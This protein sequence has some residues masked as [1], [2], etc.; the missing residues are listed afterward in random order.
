M[1]AALV[2]GAL[3][4]G[5]L[6]VLFDRLA[7]REVRDF[8][9]AKKVNRKLLKKLETKLLSA[10]VLLNDAEEKQLTEPNVKKWLDELKQVLYDADHVMDKINSEALRLKLEKGQ[11]GSGKAS[12]LL[13]FVPTV[14]I[15]FENNVKR[16]LEGILGALNFLLD[17]T[18]LLGLKEVDQKRPPHRLYS[19]LVEEYGVFGRKE[20]KEAIVELLLSDDVGGNGYRISIIPIV[21][22]GGVGK[23]T[24][25]QLV[26][27]ESSVQRHFDLKAWVTVS[28]EFDIFRI[29][30]TILESVTLKKCEIEDIHQLQIELS[31]ALTG[32][33]FLFVHDDVWNENYQLWDLLKSS[34]ESGAHGS[35]IIVTTRSKVVALKMGNIPM[36]DLQTMSDDDCWQLFSKHVFNNTGSD[37]QMELLDIGKQIVRKCKGLPLAV[38][39]VSGLLRSVSNLEEWRTILQSDVWELQFQENQNNNILPALWLSYH[40]LPRHLKQCFAYFSIFPKDY[41][42]YKSE[43]EKIFL[44]WMAEGILQPQE[45]KRMEDV[46][47]EYLNALISRSFFQRSTR[48][49]STLFMHDLTHDL[50]IRVSGEF[51][52]IDH[53]FEDLHSLTSKT[54]HLSY[55]KG[56]D[57][58]KKLE[59][60]FEAKRLRTLLSLPLSHKNLYSK[61]MLTQQGVHELLLTTRGCLRVLS[62]SQSS[63]V[64]LP[65]S[66]GNL[67]HLRYLDV[68]ET[69]VAELPC[70]VCSLYNLQTLLLSS[71]K[72]LTHL[73]T[74]ISKLIN[75]RH[76]MIRDT[77]LKEM[78]PQMCN[79]TNLQRLSDFVLSKGDGSR[80]SEL[81]ALQFLSGSLCIF[82]L[83]NVN[84]VRDA[85]EANLGNKKHLSELI[86]IWDGETNDSTKD[87]EVLEAL[88]PHVNL[89]KLKISGYPGTNLPNWVAHP[90][91]SSLATISLT[92]L[93]NC[94]L[95]PSFSQLVSLRELQIYRLDRF[96]TIDD[97]FSSC[98]SPLA[99]P[100]QCLV[101]LEVSRMSKW[102]WS[103]VDGGDNEGSAFPCL[104]KFSLNSCRKLSVGLPACYLPSLEEITIRKCHDMVAVF[105]TSPHIDT[106]YPSLEILQLS[107]C[108][109]LKSFSRMGLPSSLKS[110]DFRDCSALFANRMCWNLQRASSLVNFTVYGSPFGGNDEVD[111][112]S[113]PEKG[114][115]PSTLRCLSISGFENLKALNSKGFKH[116]TSFQALTLQECPQLQCLPNKGLPQTLT[117]LE[118]YKCP[119]LTPRCRRKIGQDWSKIQHISSIRIDRKEI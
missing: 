68:S 63:I 56:F 35:K 46:G 110:V 78:P 52:F 2:G 36:Y 9:G 51:C 45:G 26:Y 21:G 76:L 71:C 22:M 57:N 117:S 113:F 10:A 102:E 70:S 75:L 83:E 6:N 20:E 33:K 47:E 92:R 100:F 65:D 38:K 82:G 107:S 86:L 67:K 104:K 48:D 98:T 119:S 16:E 8:F 7:S 118:I 79:L 80:I 61:P 30:K 54:R 116:L 42:F 81:G 29:T 53:T 4:S 73:P 43:R 15:L 34:F 3:L 112:D 31:K 12:K 103:F 5:F 13:K 77:P 88:Q 18:V 55:M 27:K 93:T 101:T 28:E 72:A 84:D 60:S 97:E 24:L 108:S 74:N 14:F 115:L 114:L 69:R 106:A 111:M 109:R 58:L 59:G 17:Q 87:R 66:I 23:T 85:A 90:S 64:E 99:N 39:S 89:K 105:P 49:E 94:C 40:F 62:L 41:T 50:A 25:A 44:L 19:P 91:Y 95:L 11:T 1:A 37:V 32:K 96:L